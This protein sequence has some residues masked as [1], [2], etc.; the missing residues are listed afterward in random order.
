MEERFCE[1]LFSSLFH[2]QDLRPHT[3][4][5]AEVSGFMSSGGSET[6]E[7]RVDDGGLRGVGKTGSFDNSWLEPMR[8]SLQV[9]S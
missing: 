1:R 3:G 2:I 5:E 9:L 8:V 6:R 4:Q 7:E